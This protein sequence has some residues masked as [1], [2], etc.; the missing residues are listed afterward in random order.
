M[1]HLLEI[2]GQKV[3]LTSEQLARIAYVIADAE[4]LQQRYVG[5]TSTTKSSYQPFIAPMQ[6]HDWFRTNMVHED[7]IDTLKL[8]E[9]LQAEQS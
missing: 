8:A 6:I 9:K 4:L 7:Y 5:S 1:K 3:L 2:S